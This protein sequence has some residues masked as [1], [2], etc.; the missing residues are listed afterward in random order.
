MVKVSTKPMHASTHFLY[1]LKMSEK[2]MF[3]GG[4]ERNQYH[5]MG[6]SLNKNVFHVYLIPF[7][8][9]VAKNFLKASNKDT[10]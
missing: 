5:K 2:P 6:Q 9:K 1:P 3:S 8:N 7:F 4:I 10:T